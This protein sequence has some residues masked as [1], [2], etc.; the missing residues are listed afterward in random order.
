MMVLGIL[1][2]NEGDISKEYEL[3]QFAP[4]G[5]ATSDKET[6]KMTRKADYDDAAKYIWSLAGNG[7]SFA[8]GMQNYLLSIGVSQNTIDQFR[9]EMLE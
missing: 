7:G 5:W 6:T 8:D 2:V 9:S 3:T 1:G 4:H